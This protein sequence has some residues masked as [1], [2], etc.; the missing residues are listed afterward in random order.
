VTLTSEWSR[1][2]WRPLTGPVAGL[3]DGEGYFHRRPEAVAANADPDAVED[4]MAAQIERALSDGIRPTHIDAHMGTAF[5]PQFIE[6]LWKLADRYRLPLPVC[7]DMIRLFDI[8]RMHGLDLGYFREVL[9]EAERRRDPVFE[10]FF[11]GF[12]PEGQ[13]A[14]T[15]YASMANDASEGQHW[16]A[17]HANSPDDL[18][19]YAPHMARA[20]EAEYRCFSDKRSADLFGDAALINWHDLKLPEA[21]PEA[22]PPHRPE[23]ARPH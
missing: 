6:R 13:T 17:M 20:R 5:L 2:R 8:V 22:G 15:F 12:T 14:E 4:E 11:I 7:R 10:T 3:V 23:A 9:A 1:Y 16:L 19:T 18:A 21:R